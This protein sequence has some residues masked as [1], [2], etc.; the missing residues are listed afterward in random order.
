MADELKSDESQPF[1]AIGNAQ[2]EPFPKLH[3]FVKWF[4]IALGI[5]FIAWLLM[6]FV[7]PLRPIYF[8]AYLPFF[9]IFPGPHYPRYGLAFFIL[10]LPLAGSVTY[11]VL[12][13]VI[14]TRICD[15]SQQ[16]GTFE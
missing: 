11:S 10:Y 14:A 13:G 3:P 12:A 8:S 7:Y 2:C 1:D 5:Q 15:R 9:F 4:G 16:R 6:V